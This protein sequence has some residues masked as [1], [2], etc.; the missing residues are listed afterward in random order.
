M[1]QRNWYIA[2][3]LEAAACLLLV[4]LL[5][6]N[7]GEGGILASLT[8]FPLPR[9]AWGCGGCPCPGRWATGWPSGS[10]CCSA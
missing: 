8:A 9:S 3:S 5:G 4:V 10:M 6:W 2:L 7:S 1:G